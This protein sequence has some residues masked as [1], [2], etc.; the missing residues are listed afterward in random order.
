MR[1]LTLAL[2]ASAAVAMFVTAA[3][4][5]PSFGASRA[6]GEATATSKADSGAT[7]LETVAALIGFSTTVK[8][9]PNASSQP[10]RSTA[11]RGEQCDEEKKRAETAKA[12]EPPRTAAAEKRP[13][14]GE[15]VYLAF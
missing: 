15:P 14:G 8:A 12:S 7:F 3:D 9:T 6:G 5:R 11:P 1:S 2:T 10:P 13:R 4:A